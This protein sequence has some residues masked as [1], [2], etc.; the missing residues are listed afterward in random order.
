MTRRGW[1][2]LGCVLVGLINCRLPKLPGS[3]SGGPDASLSDAAPATPAADAA[4][5]APVDAGPPPPCVRINGVTWSVC[6][7]AVD[8]DGDG[9]STENGSRCVMPENSLARTSPWCSTPIPQTPYEAPAAT[10]SDTTTS[11]AT[12]PRPARVTI[13]PPHDC[14]YDDPS[15]VPWDPSW[16]GADGAIT[17]PD[18]TRVL[19]HGNDDIPETTLIRSLMIP[20]TSALVL[21]DQ[22]TK[23]KVTDVMVRGA[24]RIGSPTCRMQSDITV[25]FDTD[26]QVD[27]SGVRKDI[28]DRMGLGIM[29]DHVGTFEA[30]GRLFQPTWTRLAST[31]VP[32]TTQ[33]QLSEAVDWVSGQAIV[34]VTSSRRDYPYEDQNEVLTIG[35]VSGDGRIVTV[36]SPVKYQHYAGPEYQVEV[37]L[38]SHNIVF[39]TADRVLAANPTFG[40]H[41]MSHSPNTRI[42][43]AELYGMGQQN[44]LARY[45]FHFHYAGDVAQNGYFTDSSVW[46]SNWRCAVV[47][48]T[49]RAIVSRNVSFDTWGHCYYLEDGVEMNNEISF[50][51]AAKTKIMGPVDSASLAAFNATD[52]QDGFTLEQSEEMAQPADRAAAGFYFTNGNNRIVGNAS[53]GGFSAYSFPNLPFAINGSEDRI[54]PIDYGVSYFD[55]N[56]A[57]SSGYLWKYAGCVYEG[58]TLRETAP[59]HL[60]YSSGRT[61]DP[62]LLRNR[63]EIFNNTKTF[64]CES[65]IVHWGLRPR[66]VNLEGWDNGILATLF[67]SAS[68]QSGLVVGK[69]P[70]TGRVV[71]PQSYWQRGFQFYDTWT[72]T[73]LKDVAFR[74]F[75][76]EPCST[77]Q[78]D[79][80]ACALL[81]MTHSDQYTPQRMNAVAGLHFANVEDTQ[82]LCVGRGS[83][84]GTTLSSRNFNVLDEDGSLT[85]SPGDGQRHLVASGYVDTWKLSSNCVH[86]DAWGAWTCPLLGSQEVA[87]IRIVPNSDVHVTMYGIDSSLL[88]ET[89]YSS[90]NHA[91]A[92]ITAPSGIGWH[93]AFP[94]GVVPP[95]LNVQAIQV[96]SASFVL[97]SFSLPPGVSCTIGSLPQASSLA[98]VLASPSATYTT[99][100]N[101]CFIRLGPT[102]NGVFSASG[103]EIP[104]FTTQWTGTTWLTVDT[105]CTA[106]NPECQSVVST[107][108]QLP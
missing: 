10:V 96:P 15:L 61:T 12:I 71:R 57:H 54:F 50:N 37:G 23:L 87:S 73:I 95:S 27:Q 70:N 2:W 52:L 60:V 55:G 18:G 107:L 51:L 85:A 4:P 65:G 17:I 43:G 40:G 104:N 83:T 38:L 94:G 76:H 3:P 84:T 36:T 66:A 9:W 16:L 108:P 100:Q 106:A 34:L 72:Q 24:L 93:H 28:Y 49:N 99:E 42:S 86:K 5:E 39:R 59:G 64:M 91:D 74:E 97:L 82:R 14:P 77:C 90:Q 69:T 75:H 25:T 103:L 8:P 26:E 80:D 45:P 48:R 89:Y 101:T 29:V 31:A 7:N 56:T 20:P 92:Q 47:H 105:G 6:Q 11:V 22:P 78:K 58:G 19:L 53:S 67:G 13:D 32:N 46:R 33:L 81:S 68:I 98:A 79:Q 88:G 21:A 102:D 30:F 63:L 35:S 44:L 62:K 41:I 1:W